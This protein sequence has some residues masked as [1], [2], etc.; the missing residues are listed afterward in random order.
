MTHT[1]T[2]GFLE[3]AA[4]TSAQLIYS[5][6]ARD[7]GL[8]ELIELFVNCLPQRLAQL[9]QL[10]EQQDWEGLRRSAHQLKGAA[11]SYGFAVIS[12]KAAQLEAAA[13]QATEPSVILQLLAELEDLASRATSE[14]PPY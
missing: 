1:P 6:L 3:Q 8:R 5:P 14:A 11:G 9:R 2:V 10:A 12:V 13:R 7:T 4:A